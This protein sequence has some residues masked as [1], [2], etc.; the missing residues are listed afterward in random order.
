MRKLNILFTFSPP[1]RIGG[2]FRSALA[3]ARGLNDAGYQIHLAAPAI[4]DEMRAEF[5]EANAEFHQVPGLGSR[6]RLPLPRGFRDILEIVR[7]HSIDLIHAQDFAALSAS[8]LA[9]M[10]SKRALV[11]TKAGG[12][13]TQNVPPDDIQCVFYSEELFSGLVERYGLNPRNI[14]VN[15]ARIDVDL[16]KPSPVDP[17]FLTKYD[18]PRSSKKLA[19]AMR[20]H[21]GKM[22]WFD[23]LLGI[24]DRIIREEKDIKLILC[25]EGP[26]LPYL[27]E[28]AAERNQ[29][30]KTGP[31]LVL[32]GPIFET[33]ELT[34]LY[35]YADLVIGNGRGILE[36]MACRKPVIILGENSEGECVNATNVDEIAFYN[37]A[38]RHFRFR[39]A[40]PGDLLDLIY[41]LL[42]DESAHAEAA[43]FSYN[44]IHR[45]MDAR[46]GA[47]RLGDIYDKALRGRVSLLNFLR[48]TL[49]RWLLEARATLSNRLGLKS[50]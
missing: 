8:Y 34:Q 2:H 35:N 25:G 29:R 46:I 11:Y 3:L 24:A 14:T 6:Y 9:S 41:R 15:P 1:I 13:V 45:V 36:A 38:G 50:E 48:W 10:L 47:E 20:F 19:M 42:E 16:Y 18:L 40:S 4:T 7:Q 22:R 21:K 44:F 12:P 5:R 23:T 32:P 17:T 49:R 39:D 30:S 28:Q 27:K 26:L 31:V 33:A 43:E 37:F